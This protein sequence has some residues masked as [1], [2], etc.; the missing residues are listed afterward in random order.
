VLV[1]GVG[2]RT[3]YDVTV[4]GQRFLLASPLGSETLAGTQ[5]VL[6]WAAEARRQ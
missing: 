2:P 4:D 1:P 3:H 5:V 6:N